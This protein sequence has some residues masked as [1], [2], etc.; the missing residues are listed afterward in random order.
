MPSSLGPVRDGAGAST[1]GGLQSPPPDRR[2]K[3]ILQ[4]DLATSAVI[5]E[6][7]SAK[8]AMAATGVNNSYIGRVCNGVLPEA[9]GYRWKWKF[10]EHVQNSTSKPYV[11]KVG[12]RIG[13]KFQRYFR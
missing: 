1:V 9:G 4:L 5:A 3:P 11:T 13:A 10:G 7:K 8:A 12:F 2:S 6:F